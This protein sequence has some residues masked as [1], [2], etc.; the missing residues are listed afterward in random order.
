MRAARSQADLVPFGLVA[1]PKRCF[2]RFDLLTT[3]QSSDGCVCLC[4]HSIRR[5]LYSVTLSSPG[6][7][8]LELS[9][10]TGGGGKDVC[11]VRTNKGGLG[12]GKES[13]DVSAVV[14]ARVKDVGV[15]CLDE[16]LKFV[17]VF[18]LDGVNIQKV[19]FHCVS[20]GLRKY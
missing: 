20:P 12:V 6:G 1:W 15:R 3:Y 19:H 18:L 10:T 16:F 2:F 7:A 17:Q 8:D 11:E 13:S 9:S 5:L 14:A 4:D